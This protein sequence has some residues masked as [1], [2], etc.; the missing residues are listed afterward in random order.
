[1]KPVNNTRPSSNSN[2]GVQTYVE[3]VYAVI[4]FTNL[5]SA[6]HRMIM[7]RP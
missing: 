7:D 5:Y 2:A 1:M 4:I 6:F 3:G